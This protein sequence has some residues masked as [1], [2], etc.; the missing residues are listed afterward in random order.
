MFSMNGTFDRYVLA[1]CGMKPATC[2]LGYAVLP[3]LM[4]FA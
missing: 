1:R 4:A 2:M 3:P